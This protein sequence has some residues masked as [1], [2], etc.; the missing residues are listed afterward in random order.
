MRPLTTRQ[1]EVLRVLCDCEGWVRPMDL[2]ARDGSLSR[3]VRHGFA[4][5]RR[6][7]TWCGTRGSYHEYRAT[8]RGHC[9]R[10]EIER[11]RITRK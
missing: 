9:E 11:V 3:L 1:I 6:S 10:V 7:V 8:A 5:R 4:E 2:G